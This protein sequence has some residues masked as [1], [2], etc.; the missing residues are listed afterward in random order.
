MEIEE[1][2]LGRI[3]K[4][5]NLRLYHGKSDEEIY[6]AIKDKERQR[7]LGMVIEKTDS[8]PE[9]KFK[10]LFKKLRDEYGV[11]M[12]ES[13]DVEALKMLAQHTI[14]LDAINTQISHITGQGHLSNDDTRT[15]KNLGDIQRTT[16]MSITDLQDRLGI[17]RKARKEKQSDSLPAFIE[18]LKDK[19]ADYW[20][21]STTQ[22]RCETCKIELLR[23]WKN[24]PKRKSLITAELECPKCGQQTLH[25]G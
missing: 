5:R 1:E 19:A 4:M 17:S 16:M 15:L 22:V 3:K 11:D 6:R 9:Q 14:Q 10:E 24:F 20:E 12:N 2:Y 23:Y 13:N 7:E 25:V 21:R 8:T 18:K